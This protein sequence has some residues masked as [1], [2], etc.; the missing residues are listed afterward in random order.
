MCIIFLYATALNQQCQH[1]LSFTLLL[2][3]MVWSKPSRAAT[4]YNQVDVGYDPSSLG[5]QPMRACHKAIHYITSPT[6][7]VPKEKESMK[8]S[9]SAV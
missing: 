9:Y 8:K 2:A 3:L 6:N 7:Q 4:A 1:L 5:S